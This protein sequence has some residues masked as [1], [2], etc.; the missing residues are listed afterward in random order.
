[1]FDDFDVKNFIIGILA[2][3]VARCAWKAWRRRDE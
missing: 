2:G 1:M 3:L